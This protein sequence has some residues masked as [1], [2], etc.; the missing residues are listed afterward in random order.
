MEQQLSWSKAYIVSAVIHLVIFLLLAIGLAV[1]VAEKEQQTYEI[2]LQASDFSQGSGHA[3]GGGGTRVPG[4]VAPLSGGTLAS[5]FGVADTSGIDWIRWAL[6]LI[7][8]IGAISV[9]LKLA[10]RK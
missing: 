3:G 5:F 8:A 2:D 1:V 9:Y 4:S 7:A 10:G 6:S